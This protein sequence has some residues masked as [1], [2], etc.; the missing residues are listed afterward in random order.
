M[1]YSKHREGNMPCRQQFTVIAFVLCSL[2][3]STGASHADRVVV[4]PLGAAKQLGNVVTV[5]KQHGDFTDPAAA[6]ASITDAS[7]DNPYLLLIGPGVY[8]LSRQLVAKPYVR[9]QGSGVGTTILKGAVAGATPAD[10]GLIK[11]TY[12]SNTGGAIEISDLTLINNGKGDYSGGIYAAF[13]AIASIVIQHTD[14]SISSTDTA[15]GISAESINP[16]SKVIV[17]NCNINVSSYTS[18]GIRI[19]QNK[20]LSTVTCSS[21]N[22]DATYSGTGILSSNIQAKNLTIDAKT[23]QGTAA[24]IALSNT[25]TASIIHDVEINS[26]DGSFSYGIIISAAQKDIILEDI[27]STTSNAM[28][29]ICGL[30][31]ENSGYFVNVTNCMFVSEGLSNTSSVISI[32]NLGSHPKFNNVVANASNGQTIRAVYNENSSPIFFNLCA[33]AYAG[34]TSNEGMYNDTGSNPNIRHSKIYGQNTGING[35]HAT[36][37]IW[38]TLIDTASGGNSILNDTSPSSECH[39]TIDSDYS[40]VNC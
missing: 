31:I 18:H 16:G 30:S 27:R 26:R 2:L 37:R 39:D 12:P 14:I 19:P 24:G 8:T 15:F 10:G 1:E 7:E 21:I 25:T 32:E 36:T 35:V 22:I 11:A 38:D 20:I 13:N 28:S 9:I 4:V 17:R 23:L 6:M 29:D 3:L 33:I 40:P 5:A 34:S